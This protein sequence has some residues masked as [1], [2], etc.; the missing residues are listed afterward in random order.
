MFASCRCRRRATPAEAEVSEE[1]FLAADLKGVEEPAA[2]LPE[3]RLCPM[4][5]L[6]GIC[7]MAKPRVPLKAGEKPPELTVL[8]FLLWEEDESKVSVGIY[9]HSNRHWDA[10]GLPDTSTK[11]EIRAQFRKLSMKYH[12]DKN[13]EDG[14]KERFQKIKE[15]YEALKETN[16]ELGFPWDK[17]PERQHEM[18]PL[19]AMKT[20]GPLAEEALVTDPIKGQFMTHVGKEATSCRVLRYDRETEDGAMHTKETWADALIV[21]DRS[22]ANHLVKVYR[23]IVTLDCD[24]DNDDLDC[25]DE[26]GQPDE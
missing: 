22:G 12:P 26:M 6:V 8:M 5:G 17:Y 4:T 25:T 18:T 15:A 1:Q 2:K 24:D 13:H 10:L 14:A 16:G 20:F 11:D 23:K 21:D 3:G 9:P 19:E 7:P